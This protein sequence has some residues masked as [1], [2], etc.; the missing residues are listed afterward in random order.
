M[1]SQSPISANRSSIS[2]ASSYPTI[3]KIINNFY[4]QTCGDTANDSLDASAPPRSPP[5]SRTPTPTTS[6]TYSTYAK[7]D[8]TPG[9]IIPDDSNTPIAL[10]RSLQLQDEDPFIVEPV[11]E[12]ETQAPKILV[13]IPAYNEAKTIADVVKE[14]RR[15]AS[16]VI[17]VDRSTPASGTLP[18][19]PFHRGRVA[20][21]SVSRARLEGDTILDNSIRTVLATIALELDRPH[22]PDCRAASTIRKLHAILRAVVIRSYPDKPRSRDT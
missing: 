3:S 22:V 8:S 18:I 7:A 15:F 11:T 14:A 13:A 12:K 4:G 1:Y 6:R 2:A 17:V 10:E 16:K 19:T 21:W 9:I 20:S 5:R